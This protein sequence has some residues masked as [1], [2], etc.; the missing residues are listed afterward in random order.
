MTIADVDRDGIRIAVAKG[1]AYDLFLTRTL[2]HATLNAY[3]R[4]KESRDMDI[5]VAAVSGIKITRRIPNGRERIFGY[6]FSWLRSM[7]FARPR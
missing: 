7:Q 3:L 4:E 5:G 1:S 6:D 2:Q